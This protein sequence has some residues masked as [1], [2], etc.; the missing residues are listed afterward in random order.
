MRWA[1]GTKRHVKGNGEGKRKRLYEKD[2]G[3]CE[4]KGKEGEGRRK[5]GHILDP[6]YL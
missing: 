4:R 5:G 2:R 6:H 1:K 3:S